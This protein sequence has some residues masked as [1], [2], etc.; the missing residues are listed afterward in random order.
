MDLAQG[1]GGQRLVVEVL[2]ELGGGL[3][4]LTLDDLQRPRPTSE[5]TGPTPCG[6]GERGGGRGHFLMGRFP[7]NT[8]LEGG[9]GVLQVTLGAEETL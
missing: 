7:G 3:S 1:G 2:E 6:C 9:F 8:I 4:Q 5:E